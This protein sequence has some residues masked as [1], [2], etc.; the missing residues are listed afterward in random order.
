[1]NL[2]VLL[3]QHDDEGEEEEENSKNEADEES[4]YK[5]VMAKPLFDTNEDDSDD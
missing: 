3:S 5:S 2:N 1:M 4:H